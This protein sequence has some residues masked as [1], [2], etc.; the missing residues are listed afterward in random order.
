MHVHVFMGVDGEAIMN[1]MINTGRGDDEGDYT[2]AKPDTQPG[3]HGY[4]IGVE[5]LFPTNGM[6]TEAGM[7]AAA[8]AAT[9]G[10]CFPEGKR[11]NQRTASYTPAEDKVH[12]E[13]WLE[14]STDSICGAEQ[15]GFN[16][17][18]MWGNSSTSEGRFVRNHSKAIGMTS[19]FPRDGHHPCECSMFQGSFE[20][21]Q[22]RQ[23]SGLSAV[24]MVKPIPFLSLFLHMHDAIVHW[25]V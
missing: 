14:I 13:A 12:C 20:K 23:I 24:D 1:D 5:P 4:D 3:Q 22:K 18:R 15:K 8:L 16:Y 9:L 25:R 21:I 6:P 17:W 7:S 2:Q 10:G 11:I 19:P